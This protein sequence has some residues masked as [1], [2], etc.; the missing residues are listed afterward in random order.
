MQIIIFVTSFFIFLFTLYR[1]VRDDHI[2]LRKNIK[3]EQIFD[4]VFIGAAIAIIFSQVVF[5][6]NSFIL[7][8][9]VIFGTLGLFLISKYRKFPVGRVIDFFALSFLMSL[10]SG[11]LITALF[12]KKTEMILHLIAA[13]IYFLLA[14]FFTKTLLPKIMNRTLK[15]GNLSIYFLLFFSSISLFLSTFSSIE[16]HTNFLIPENIFLIA[17]FAVSVALLIKQNFTRT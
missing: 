17:I 8:Q 11:F 9:G 15:E 14:L 6:K 3:L 2:F 7:P 5:P 1:L 10:P 12:S 16:R 4:I 13:F